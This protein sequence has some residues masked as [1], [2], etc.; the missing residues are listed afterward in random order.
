MAELVLALDLP[1]APDAERLLDRLEG[2]RWV[3]I[4]SVLFTGAGPAFVERLKH[5]GLAVFLD[6]KWHDIP[7]TVAG[8]VRQAAGLGVDMVTVHTLGGGAMLH[9]AG[10]AAGERLAVV[11]VSVLTSHTPQEWAAIVGRP[12]GDLAAEVTRLADLARTAGIAGVVSSP[13]ET[14]RL[15]A[16]LG[17]EALLVTPGIRA[18]GEAAG[19]QNRTAAAPDAVRAGS[20]HLVVGRPVLQA[21]DPASAW[22][23]L[24]A[25]VA[26]R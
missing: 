19:D 23:S 25:S 2:V 4:G 5:R 17:P 26:A 6:L 14:A 1:T 20:T 18:P 24:L 16:L 22:S 15:R 3:K 8:A 21:S 11:G 7:N 13:L 9:A 10:E 12:A